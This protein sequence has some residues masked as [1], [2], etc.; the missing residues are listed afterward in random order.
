M[1]KRICQYYLQNLSFV[2]FLSIFST[3]F[4]KFCKPNLAKIDDD[5]IFIPKMQCK[6]GIAQFPAVFLIFRG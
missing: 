6:V 3:F 5:F 2:Y 1:Y 4:D